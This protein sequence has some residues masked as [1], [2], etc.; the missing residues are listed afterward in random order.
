MLHGEGLDEQREAAFDD[1]ALDD[2]RA[3]ETG[4]EQ[5]AQVRLKIGQA[6]SQN[7]SAHARRNNIGKKKVDVGSGFLVRPESVFAGIGYYDIV[8]FP[9][10][11]CAHKFSNLRFVIYDQDRRHLS[12]CNS[13]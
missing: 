7:G 2:L 3:I 11:H 13:L 6:I 10:E 1:I 5:D 12:D 9:C 8:T 4:H